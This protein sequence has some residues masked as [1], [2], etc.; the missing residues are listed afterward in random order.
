MAEVSEAEARRYFETHR[1]EFERPERVRLRDITLESKE[2]AE[3]I[4]QALRLRNGTNFADLARHFSVNPATRQHGG[5]MGVVSV[6]DL[7]PS[8][9]N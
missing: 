3:A 2:N 8:C 1:D 5:D 7:H 6:R 9:G 4:Y